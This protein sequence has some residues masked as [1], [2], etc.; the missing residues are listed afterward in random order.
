MPEAQRFQG[1]MDPARTLD[2]VAR[3]VSNVVSMPE[4]EPAQAGATAISLYFV[5]AV[6]F[7]SCARS[8]L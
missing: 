1:E 3:L 7:F 6:A 5:E 2:G 8:P 4:D